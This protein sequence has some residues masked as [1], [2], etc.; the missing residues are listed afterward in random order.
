M[1]P[2]VL[3]F[4]YWL[5]FRIDRYGPTLTCDGHPDFLRHNEGMELD[6]KME[7]QLLHIE[8]AVLRTR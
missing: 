4:C 6:E 1:S 7:V 2:V 5:P 8:I 3:V